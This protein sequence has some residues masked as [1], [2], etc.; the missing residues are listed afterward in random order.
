MPDLPSGRG[1]GLVGDV[2]HDTRT[3][4]FGP[5]GKMYVSV[6]SSCDQCAEGDPRRAAVLQ[7]NPDGS[8]GRVFAGGLRNAVGLGVDPGTGLLWATVNE[9]NALGPD[10]PPDLFVPLRD[11]VNYGWPYCLAT[12]PRPDPQLGAGREE[13]CRSGVEPAL[14][15]IRA[16]SA[17]LGLR[18]SAGAHFPAPFANGVFVALHGPFAQAPLYGHRVVFL[19]MVPGKL[20]QGFQDFAVGWVGPD[21]GNRW[22]SPV[23]VAV[24]ADGALYISDDRAGAVY[25]VTYGP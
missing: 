7:F 25:R 20:Q 5:D 22:G 8:G 11:G 13:F 3:I 10:E 4:V 19:S 21:G 16:H 6:G 23:D 18:F 17:P 1:S 9:R 12:P 24:G 15:T 2:N 14:V